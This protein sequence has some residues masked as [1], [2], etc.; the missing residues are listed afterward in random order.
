MYSP[1]FDSDSDE[2]S[3]S[4]FEDECSNNN[5]N[6]NNTTRVLFHLDVDYFYAQ[7]EEQQLSP[8]QRQQPIAVGQKH[9]IVTCNYVARA[10]GVKKLML[11]TEARR[12]C[13]SLKIYNGSDLERYRRYSTSIYKTLRQQVASLARDYGIQDTMIAMKKGGFD[14]ATCDVTFLVNAI[15]ET[16]QDDT[17]G[18]A[19]RTMTVP[20][21]AF[22]YG[23]ESFSIVLTEDQS[24]AQSI[25]R[26]EAVSFPHHNNDNDNAVIQQQRLHVAAACAEQVRQAIFNKTGFTTSIGV[27]TSPMLCKI[28]SSLRK[29]NG[30]NILYPWRA[31]SLVQAL[32]LRSVPQL[33]SRTLKALVPCLVRY[34]KGRGD[35]KGSF[36]TCR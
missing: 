9:I 35:D 23:N 15:L 13:P 21:N 8:Q 17:N 34:N 29:P 27:S 6:N 24:G 5:N 28:A 25:V 12:V 18:G 3:C 10:H 32:P 31:L 14:E 4:S 16:R 22:I 2:S 1:S 26:N 20:S 11:Q 7:C 36:W 30:L 33:G 19:R